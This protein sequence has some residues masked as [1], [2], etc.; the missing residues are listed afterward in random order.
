MNE[1]TCRKDASFVCIKMKRNL[2]VKRH[3]CVVND[4]SIN[5]LT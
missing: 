3:A 1:K 4:T 2:Y 5:V